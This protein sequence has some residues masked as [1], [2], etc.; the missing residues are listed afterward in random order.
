MFFV[1]DTLSFADDRLASFSDNLNALLDYCHD[2]LRMLLASE[3]R[4]A[5]D[6]HSD[7]SQ[8]FCEDEK[9]RANGRIDCKGVEYR[10]TRHAC[11]VESK[12]RGEESDRSK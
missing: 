12:L 5:Y 1:V 6:S 7:C 11:S 3:G 10:R 8:Y 9:G 4:Y 2:V